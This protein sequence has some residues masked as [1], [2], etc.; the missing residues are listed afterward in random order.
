[1]FYRSKRTLGKGV[2]YG[3]RVG[4]AGKPMNFFQLIKSN[5]KK[6]GKFIELFGRKNQLRRGW[7]IVGD[8]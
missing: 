7:M 5:F 3:I 8:D 4:N 6:R 2:L 1:M